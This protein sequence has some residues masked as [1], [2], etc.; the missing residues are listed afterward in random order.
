LAADFGTFGFY[1]YDGT[2]TRISTGDADQDGGMIGIAL[3]LYVDFG[4]S[5]LWRYDGAT[6]TQISTGNTE[7]LGAYGSKLVADFGTHGLYE[8]DG[9]PWTRISTGNCE[10]MVEM[11]IN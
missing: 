6:W 5:G 10:D 7:G 9:S 2:W 3:D 4:G 1:L 11:N 8:Y